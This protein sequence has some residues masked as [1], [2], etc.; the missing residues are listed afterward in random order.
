MRGSPVFTRNTNVI[1]IRIIPLYE[2]ID[3]F[4][5]RVTGLCFLE[6]LSNNSKRIERFAKP[7]KIRGTIVPYEIPSYE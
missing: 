2:G 3:H 6:E 1:L 4:C 5:V 7:P